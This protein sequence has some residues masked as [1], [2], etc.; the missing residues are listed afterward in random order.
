[1]NKY[2]LLFVVSAAVAAVSQTL[3]K[4]ASIRSVKKK[5]SLLRSLLD[6]RVFL[7]YML[8]LC[9]TLLNMVGYRY[10]PLSLGGLVNT[11]SYV[12]VGIISMVVFH[13]KLSSRSL[14][15]YGLII[16]GVIIV[17]V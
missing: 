12:F 9:T 11:L 5:V 3:L 15:S 4:W 6:W 17:L 13:E 14:M 16:A 10:N 1:M 7:G 8:L 2:V